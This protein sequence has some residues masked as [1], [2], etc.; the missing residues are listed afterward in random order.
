MKRENRISRYVYPSRRTCRAPLLSR[1]ALGRRH[2]R[3][4]DSQSNQ[5]NATDETRNRPESTVRA[6]NITELSTKAAKQRI[7]KESQHNKGD[8]KRQ[9]CALVEPVL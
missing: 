5:D 3:G 6:G 1:G 4:N 8:S 7:R 2:V 9:Y